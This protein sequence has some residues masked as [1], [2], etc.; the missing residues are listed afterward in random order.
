MEKGIVVD[1]LRAAGAAR[2]AVWSASY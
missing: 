1:H 2:N